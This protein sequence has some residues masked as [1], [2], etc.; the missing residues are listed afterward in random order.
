[1]RHMT[2]GQQVAQSPGVLENPL[3]STQKWLFRQA[4]A[5]RSTGQAA[6]RTSKLLPV[7]SNS[8]SWLPT[9]QEQN[10]VEG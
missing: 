2:S 4:S 5:Q 1:M 10:R 3:L 9:N 8:I 6:C 7:E